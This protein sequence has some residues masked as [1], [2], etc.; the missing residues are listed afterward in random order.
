MSMKTTTKQIENYESE[1]TVEFEAEELE[2]AKKRAA[3]KIAER[4]NI[5]GFRKG[6][7]PYNILEKTV[8]KDYIL[9]EA[10]DVLIQQAARDLVKNAEIVPVTEM[11]PKLITCEDG[12]NLVFTLTFTPYPKVE[13]GEYKNLEVDKVIEPVT[14]EDVNK[15]LEHLRGHHANLTEAAED[16]TVAN[17]DFVTLDFVGTVDGEKFQGGEGKDHPLDIGSHSFIGDFEEQLIGLKV[18]EE[19]DVKVT[20]PEDYRVKELADKPAVFHCKINSIKHK[21]LPALDDEFAKKVGKFESLTDLK[22]SI[23]K[24]METAA[25]RTATERQQEGVIKKAVENMTVDLPPVMV[26][27]RITQL[28]R[29]LEVQLQNQGMTIQQYLAISN[30]DMDQLRDNYREAAKENVL[31]DILCDEIARVE[32]IKVNSRE[33]DYE[34]AVMAQMYR[35]TPKQIIK[36]LRDNHQEQNIVANVRRRN[37]MQFIIAN[38]AQPKPIASAETVSAATTEAKVADTSTE[39]VETKKADT[40]KPKAKKSSKTKKSEQ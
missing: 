22:D 38:M 18:G 24:N 26:E 36:I 33:L 7:V 28:I 35:T 9:D 31:T 21:E 5:P 29:E 34:I 37:V 12:Q 17:G 6:K 30:I 16:D 13:L 10:A 19:K 1:V 14:D 40:P 2:K 20:F 3:K 23:R 39:V 25:E 15:R 4:V 32:N 27:N 11:Q 8:G